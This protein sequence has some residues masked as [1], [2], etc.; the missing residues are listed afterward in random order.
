M[1]NALWETLLAV[2][3]GKVSLNVFHF[4][5]RLTKAIEKVMICMTVQGTVP[6][7]LAF[8]HFLTY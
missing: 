5:D 4:Q 8:K 1:S 7:V 3:Q 2:W 6:T